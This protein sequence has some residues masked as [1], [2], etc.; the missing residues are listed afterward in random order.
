MFSAIQQ[1]PQTL[2]GGPDMWMMYDQHYVYNIVYDLERHQPPD[3]ERLFL[4]S[5][6][7][8]VRS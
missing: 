1:D 3:E 2:A 5:G 6:V 8:A 4:D 7:A